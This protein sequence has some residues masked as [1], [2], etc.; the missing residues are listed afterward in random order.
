MKQL[1]THFTLAAATLALGALAVTAQTETPAPSEL[2][3]T[4][5]DVNS[6][7]APPSGGHCTEGMITFRGTNYP[8]DVTLRVLSY[9]VGDLIDSA[10][11]FSSAE[12]ELSF[13]QTLVPAGTYAVHL[14][15]NNGVTLGA[16]Y[17]TV[18]PL[19]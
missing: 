1:F 7:T 3:V 17:L 6:T 14:L 9:P 18:D 10:S 2:S 13:T 15:D 8:S 19:R 12:G 5:G 4:C 16:R 11:Y